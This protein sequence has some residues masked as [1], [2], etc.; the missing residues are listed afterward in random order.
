MLPDPQDAIVGSATTATSIHVKRRRS[1]YPGVS[2][3][4]PRGYE[5]AIGLGEAAPDRNK[6]RNGNIPRSTPVLGATW[7]AITGIGIGIG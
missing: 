3:G 7:G 4:I 6:S 2:P 1:T 5:A